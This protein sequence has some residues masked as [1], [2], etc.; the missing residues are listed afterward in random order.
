M[1]IE[2]VVSFPQG[3]QFTEMTLADGALCH[4]ITDDELERLGDM[5]KE[6]VMEI[7]L[8]AIGAFLGALV[9]AGQVVSQ[10]QKDPSQ[11][12]LVDLVILIVAAMTLAAAVVSGF[13]WHQR[14]KTHK[15]MVTAIR[16]RP[17]IR[18]GLANETA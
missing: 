5:R 16:E 9:P 15:N 12:T 14:S 17:R 13:L 11:V 8:C 1:P 10:F 3:S 6:P 7:F 18:V 2:G 4:Y